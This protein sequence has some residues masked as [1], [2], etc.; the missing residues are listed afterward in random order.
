M[1]NF[2]LISLILTLLVACQCEKK[3]TITLSVYVGN[4][5]S[6]DTII[7]YDYDNQ[8][9]SCV[10]ARNNQGQFKESFNFSEGFYY[11]DFETEYTT[12]YLKKGYDLNISINDFDQFN[13]SIQAK[14]K[15]EKVNN[16]LFEQILD[17]NSLISFESLGD[18]EPDEFEQIK[19]QFLDE[20]HKKLHALKIKSE[21]RYILAEKLENVIK[22]YET[23]HKQQYDFKILTDTITVAPNF[24]CTDISGRVFSLSDFKGSIVYIYVWASWCAPCIMEAPYFKQLKSEFSEE[25]IQFVSISM[26]CPDQIDKWKEALK[27]HDLKGFQLI[28]DSCFESSIA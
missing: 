9:S 15:G 7:I 28:A 14:G 22:Q 25:E 8:D 5:S 21:T 20:Q 1:R 4:N 6:L 26:D 13:E 27:E 16:F 19:T 10:L 24:S 23:Y 12:V 3:N 11:L 18:L 2:A 17:R